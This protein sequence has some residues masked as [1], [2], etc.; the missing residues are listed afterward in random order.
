MYIS[1]NKLKEIIPEFAKQRLMPSAPMHIQWIIAGSTQLLPGIV[2]NYVNKNLDMLKGLGIVNEQ[3][4]VDIEV[5]KAF[6]ENAFAK[7]PKVPFIGFVFDKSDGDA[8]ISLL[9][10]FKDA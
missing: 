3:S 7:V 10:N 6:M 9:E 4:Q 5:A 2:D 8:F 1:L